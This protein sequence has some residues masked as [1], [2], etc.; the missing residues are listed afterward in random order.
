M[1]KQIDIIYLA[2]KV[3]KKSSGE[4]GADIVCLTKEKH[5]GEVQGWLWSTW[6]SLKGRS[7]CIRFKWEGSHTLLYTTPPPTP[8]PAIYR[9][10]AH[11]QRCTSV[12]HSNSCI[13]LASVKPDT[14]CKSVH[15]PSYSASASIV[16]NCH[17]AL[18]PPP[19]LQRCHYVNM[20]QETLVKQS[21]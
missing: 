19:S 5:F 8:I 12:W 1:V 10:V 13:V 20:W 4:G 14:L 15:R 17:L 6:P 11:K 7:R 3:T 2:Q 21:E 9:H 16:Q 18:Q